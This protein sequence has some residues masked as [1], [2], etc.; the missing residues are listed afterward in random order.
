[1]AVQDSP[2]WQIQQQVYNEIQQ[3]RQRKAARQDQQRQQEAALN[4]ELR[5]RSYQ[6]QD[7]RTNQQFAANTAAESHAYGIVS[8]REQFQQQYA[9]ANQRYQ[10]QQALQD[11]ELAQ[12]SQE[13]GQN[14]AQRQ[15]EFGADLG[16]RQYQFGSTM[17]QRQHEQDFYERQQE[18]EEDRRDAELTAK[19]DFQFEQQ[20]NA[21]DRKLTDQQRQQLQA[22][23]NQLGNVGNLQLTHTQKREHRKN[24]LE[25][26]RAIYQNAPHTSPEERAA[27]VDNRLKTMLGDQYEDLKGLGWQP[28]PKTGQLEPSPELARLHN[29]KLGTIEKMRI[30]EKKQEGEAHKL[31]IE[32]E[33]GMKTG[34]GSKPQTPQQMMQEGKAIDEIQSA[35]DEIAKA[36]SNGTFTKANDFAKA[37]PGGLESGNA[38][39]DKE[40][41]QQN[42][43]YFKAWQN[44]HQQQGSGQ[45]QPQQPAQQPAPQQAPQAPQQQFTNP[46]GG[47][48]TQQIPGQQPSQ[49]PGQQPAKIKA[50][51]QNPDDD[52]VIDSK[53]DAAY[54]AQPHGTWFRDENGK[55]W[56]KP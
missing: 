1:M 9:L 49:Q 16:Q 12:R 2:A 6:L 15:Y 20:L 31:A 3:Y 7:Q 40:L 30:L 14:L 50:S 22:I 46:F 26:R 38:I 29:T 54:A 18:D 48:R 43:A 32:H 23:E 53:D 56:Y 27:S 47:N 21:G 42:P 33:Y 34:P 41:E 52:N 39:I 13:F 28:N 24:L 19:E 36:I 11:Q 37:A 4:A 55:R 44:L 5:Q 45:Q 8:G 17:Q 35:R 25:Q 51:Y 10:Q